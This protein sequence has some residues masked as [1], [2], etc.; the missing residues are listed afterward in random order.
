MIAK[1]FSVVCLI[2]IL[3]IVCENQVFNV[4]NMYSVYF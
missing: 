1:N 4:N 2:T 3:P